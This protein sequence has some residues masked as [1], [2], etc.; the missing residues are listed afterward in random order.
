MRIAICDDE[1]KDLDI[2]T[3]LLE[4]YNSAD[5]LEVSAFYSGQSLLSSTCETT[6]DI[7]VLDI[8]MPQLNGYDTAL[9][10]LQAEQKPIVIFLTN[11]MAYTLRGYG[12]AFRYLAKPIVKQQLYSALDAAIREILANRFVFFVDG[13][14]HVL[15]MDEIYYLEVFNHH[16]VL[17]TVDAEYAFRSSLKEI[18]QQLPL[19]Y[20]GLP[21]QSYLINFAHI[22][23]A[24]NKEIYL[25]NGVR[26][27]V[28]RRKQRDF[29]CQFHGYLGR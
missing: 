6:Y 26:I 5:S 13:M 17:H 27:P 29:D 22:K 4:E 3:L 28:S 15:R 23:T 19:G 10:L 2:L 9:R 8:E 24:S 7:V 25:T 20:F 12:V 14:S 16:I 1:Q 18:M 21:H 11:S